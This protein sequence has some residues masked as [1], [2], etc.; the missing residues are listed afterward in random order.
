MIKLNKTNRIPCKNNKLIKLMNL[1]KSKNYKKKIK[2][3]MMIYKY[4]IPNR[5]QMKKRVIYKNSNKY[6]LI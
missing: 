4:Y 5:N 3:K 2:Q 1:I 6:K